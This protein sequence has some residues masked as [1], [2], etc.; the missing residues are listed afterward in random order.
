MKV[1]ELMTKNPTSISPD[2]SVRDAA[3]E[4]ERCDCGCL[5]VADAGGKLVGMITDRDIAIRAVAKGL[6]ADAR[7]RDVMTPN[8]ATVRATDDVKQVERVM[9]EKQVRRVP[10]VDESG[11]CCGIVAQADLA[12]AA[13]GADDISDK[14]VAQVVENISAPTAGA[15]R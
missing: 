8:P 4:M 15:A 3:K 5:P 7:V 10:V 12:R 2:Q 9:S 14:D 1:S 13:D 11:K 6:G